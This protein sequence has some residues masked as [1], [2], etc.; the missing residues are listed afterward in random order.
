M[1]NLEISKRFGVEWKLLLEEDKR[2]F[3]DEVKR[4]WVLYMKEYLDYK[5]WF[6]RKLK[7]LFKKDKYFFLMV[8]LMIFGI[9]LLGGLFLGFGFL[10]LM[11]EVMLLNEKMRV[12][13]LLFLFVYFYFSYMDG[14]GKLDSGIFSGFS[15]YDRLYFF[16]LFVLNVYFLLVVVVLSGMF[17]VVYLYLG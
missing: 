17:L 14:S 9:S 4:F 10:V 2:L 12:F 7:F 8:M 5:Y 3:I 11:L 16:Y 15:V 13:F 6:R 1:Y